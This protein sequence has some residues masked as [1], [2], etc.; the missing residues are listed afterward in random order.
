MQLLGRRMRRR[1]FIAGLCGMAAWPCAAR[2]QQS[3]S[4]IV[5]V[6]DFSGPRPKSPFIEAVRAGLAEDGFIEGSNLSIEYRSGRGNPRQ[7]ADFAAELA[8]RP[9]ALIFAFGAVAPALAAKRATSTIPIVFGYG[10]DPVKD[11]LVA[12]FNRPGGNLTGMTGLT[13]E[14][15]SKRLD[16]LLKM[17]PRARKIGFLSGTS[18][19]FA[20]EEQTSAILA[21][22]RAGGV[23]VMIV[24]C[25]D[26]REYE[27][28]L[29]KMAEGGADAMILG[30][31][32]L[33]NLQKVV[34]LAALYKL[35]AIY[36]NR[37]FADAGGLM[38]YDTDG[39][40]MGRR[41]GSA[42]AARIL[43]G[44]APGD[45]PV[46]Q[47]TKFQFVINLKTAKALGLTI[48][49]RLLA[50]ADEVIE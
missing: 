26:D 43:K 5:G 41:L 20:Y 17:V 21:A 33:P 29:V 24:E 37:V 16:L 1:D 46:E 10:G 23:E 9:V 44:K 3:A 2:A 31:F 7:I 13:G 48:P 36:P 19:F 22:G 35:P 4:P 39:V 32:A 11:G 34:P 12:S 42:Y 30:S 28:A 40:A 49:E 25:R 45:L 14:L 8:S 6:L 27:S 18:N 47:P 50:T 38:S 15:L